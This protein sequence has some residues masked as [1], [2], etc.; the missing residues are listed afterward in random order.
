M[1]SAATDDPT[2]VDT[3]PAGCEVA[4]AVSSS[5]AIRRST[6]S[7]RSSRCV[8]TE[9]GFSSVIGTFA[10]A[11]TPRSFRSERIS[12]IISISHS[13]SALASAWPNSVIAG[14]CCSIRKP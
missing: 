8:S 11:G 9:E 7:F 5:R 12:V 3:E 1:C 6:S 2:S 14:H 4:V 13:I 10:P